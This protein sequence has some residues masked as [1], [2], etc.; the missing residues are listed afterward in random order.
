MSSRSALAGRAL[1]LLVLAACGGSTRQAPT[2]AGPAGDG[3]GSVGS[4]DRLPEVHVAAVAPTR[5]TVVAQHMRDRFQ[6]LRSIERYLLA[7]ELDAVRD[8][9]TALALDRTDPTLAA[10]APARARMQEAARELATAATLEDATRLQPVLAEACGGCHLA[11]GRGP[12]FEPDPAP[13]DG[14]TA[15]ARMARHQWGADRLWEALVTPSDDAWAAGLD[16]L[17]VTPLPVRALTTVA[18]P[19]TAAPIAELGLTLQRQATAARTAGDAPARAHAYGQMLLTCA[20]C[21]QLV[22]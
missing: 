6:D 2:G 19:G 12:R 7:G 10:W 11:A 8:Y 3:G 22:K 13:D 5:A 9:A 4:P 20:R 1:W 21:H 17:A 15:E 16:V 18:P 14:P